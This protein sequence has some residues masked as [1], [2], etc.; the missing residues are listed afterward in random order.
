MRLVR[1][2]QKSSAAGWEQDFPIDLAA[3]VQPRL[4]PECGLLPGPEHRQVDAGELPGGERW[5]LASGEDRCQHR[6]AE[7]SERQDAADIGTID[8][9]LSCD[10]RAAGGGG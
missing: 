10:L 5:R 4:L 8:T 1:L 9:E 6:G 3:S 2:H 7:E